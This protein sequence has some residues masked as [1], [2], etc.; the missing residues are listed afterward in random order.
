[1]F[2]G[3]KRWRVIKKS[4]FLLLK[5]FLKSFFNGFLYL[6]GECDGQFYKFVFEILDCFWELLEVIEK[7]ILV[8]IKLNEDLLDYIFYC[9]INVIELRGIYE[10]MMEDLE[11]LKYYLMEYGIGNIYVD[12]FMGREI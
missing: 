7:N 4:F 12:D 11:N 8:L 3:V 9:C 1:M 5:L 2:G 10:C 6:E